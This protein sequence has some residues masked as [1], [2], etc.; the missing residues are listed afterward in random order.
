MSVTSR[1]F[2]YYAA[3][4]AYYL[5]FKSPRYTQ[6]AREQRWR[7]K[8][9]PGFLQTNTHKI[10][11]YS[12]INPSNHHAPV[13]VL[14]H[15]WSGRATQM[16]AFVQPLLNT[17]F[18]VVGFDAP[19]HGQSSGSE[20]NFFEIEEALSRLCTQLGRV[21]GVIAHSFATMVLAYSLRYSIQCE[22]VVLLSSPNDPAF[23]VQRFCD[24]LGF[25]EK[26][27]KLFEN[28]LEKRFNNNIWDMLSAE[29]NARHLDV[30]ALIIHDKDDPDVPAIMSKRLSNA[31]LNSEL[32]ITS[33]LGHTRILRDKDV[34]QHAV[35][36]LTAQ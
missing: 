5:W 20:T 29:M 6:P 24:S 26:A 27:K 28:K 34:I 31:W 13:I 36:F 4:R 16:G 10:A 21:H 2:P 23:L 15:G 17:G 25:S 32:L 8:A 22:R 7:E 19:G 30:P 33:G 3:E 1:V 11:L 14:M 9:A 12:W 35:A 18:S